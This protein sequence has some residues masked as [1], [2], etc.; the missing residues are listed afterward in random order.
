MNP[1]ADFTDTLRRRLRRID[2]IANMF[3]NFAE[4]DVDPDAGHVAALGE[5]VQEQC[6]ELRQALEAWERE[7]VGAS[8]ADVIALGEGTS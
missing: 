7:T 1:S 3:T 8:P 4:L 5:I 2:A 6:D